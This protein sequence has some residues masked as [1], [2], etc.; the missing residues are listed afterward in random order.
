MLGRWRRKN[1]QWGTGS[2]TTGSSQEQSAFC[3]LAN[4]SRNLSSF[5][6]LM[7]DWGAAEWASERSVDLLRE[8][9]KTHNGS[10]KRERAWRK[11]GGC[12]HIQSEGN[13]PKPSPPHPLTEHLFFFFITPACLSLFHP[14]S[15]FLHM[16][17]V[18]SVSHL[19][20]FLS[21][22][23]CPSLLLAHSQRLCPQ[24][25]PDSSLKSSAW[26]HQITMEQERIRR[27]E[28]EGTRGEESVIHC[29]ICNTLSIS[30]TPTHI[31][32]FSVSP[33]C[34]LKVKSLWFL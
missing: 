2:W 15:P 34:T 10:Q 26:N 4:R 31:L 18:S 25:Y 14:I 6:R 1:K 33:P 16:P 30:P 12:K 17:P 5:R 21:S 22:L 20:F 29:F 32:H 13:S 3:D 27:G 11:V 19:P 23:H 7:R 24:N 9:N 8:G 28:G